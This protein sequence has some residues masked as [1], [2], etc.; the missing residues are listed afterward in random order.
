[1]VSN[2]MERHEAYLYDQ[3]EK[4]DALKEDEER[5]LLAM[6]DKRKR[7]AERDTEVRDQQK[8]QVSPSSIICVIV[9]AKA[10]QGAKEEVRG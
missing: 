2:F 1:M 5:R 8:D 7:N 3:M 10:E 9:K 4:K 6:D